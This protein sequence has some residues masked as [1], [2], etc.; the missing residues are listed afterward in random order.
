MAFISDALAEELVGQGEVY[1]FLGQQYIIKMTLKYNNALLLIGTNK[2][3]VKNIQSRV[4]SQLLQ[5]PP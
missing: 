5:K 1:K 3:N 2:N 4:N